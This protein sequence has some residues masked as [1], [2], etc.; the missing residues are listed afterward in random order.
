MPRVATRKAR[1]L[2]GRKGHTGHTTEQA[3]IPLKEAHRDEKWGPARLHKRTRSATPCTERSPLGD[4]PH[5]PRRLHTDHVY[6]DCVSSSCGSLRRFS[7]SPPLHTATRRAL[8]GCISNRLLSVV[9][10]KPYGVGAGRTR[11]AMG[12]TRCTCS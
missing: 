12:C 8:P 2:T 11:A 1:H 4:R 9:A 3:A 7:S 6:A 5:Q 10:G